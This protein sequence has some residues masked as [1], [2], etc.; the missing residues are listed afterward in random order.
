M[1][2][3]I[4]WIPGPGKLGRGDI[5]SMKWRVTEM[6][7]TKWVEFS[8]EVEISLGVEDLH[9]LLA[10]SLV[11]D[12]QETLREVLHGMN[13]VLSFL[14]A[15]GDDQIAAMLPVH[16]QLVAT[17]LAEQIVRFQQQ[18]PAG[19]AAAATAVPNNEDSEIYWD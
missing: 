1:R 4:C 6:K 18:E 9:G 8:Q 15:V 16:R 3:L 12:R 2:C 14:R 19:D 11:S 13:A 7:V 10:E 17:V 5:Y